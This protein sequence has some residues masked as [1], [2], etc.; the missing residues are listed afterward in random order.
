[1][2]R[3]RGENGF[4]HGKEE[5]TGV[6][7]VNL[8]TPE[9][10]TTSAVRRYLKQF[11]SDPRVVEI[12]R[13]IWMPI[14][15]T[16]ILP[17]RPAKSAKMYQSVWTKEGSPLL[18][19]SNK[20]R[21]AVQQEMKSR[22][23]GKVIVELAMRYGKP[24]IESGLE[25]LKKQGVRRLLV[26]PLYPQYSATTTATTY[27][28]VNRV[29]SRWRWL[30][31]MRF[32]SSY[33]DHSSYINALAASVKT[34][35]E[36]HQRGQ[37]LLMSFHGLPKRNL[38][39]GDPYFCHCQKTARLLAEKL[40]LKQDQ[41]VVTFQ[42]RFGKAEWIKPYTDKTLEELPTKG[43]KHIDV[44]CPGFPAD[45]LETLEEIKIDNSDTFLQAGGET[46]RYIAALNHQQDH[47][48]ALSD[49]IQQHTQGWAETSLHWEHSVTEKR[50]KST[51]KRAKAKGADL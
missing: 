45:C 18:I 51:Q 17:R 47:I 31:E 25:Q 13:L 21:S 23:K 1:M 50:N 22:F 12:P 11:L 24:S 10:A 14:L 46:Y 15:Y 29:L 26:L 33:H 7:L 39:L 19:F 37:V 49:I 32:V 4:F 36:Q 27:D 35:W 2:R 43:I 20:Q 48:R 16:F 42:S 34:H 38:N 3:Y 6:L 28:E 9:A 8:G 40:E 5:A 41:Y 30:P 44:L